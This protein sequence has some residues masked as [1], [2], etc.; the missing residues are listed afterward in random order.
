[1]PRP[2]AVEVFPNGEIGVVWDDGREDVHASR[3]LR[4]ACP[5]AQ[6]VDEMTGKRIV[7]PG[8]VSERVRAL[9]WDP[10]GHYALRIRWSDLHDSGLY[11]FEYLRKLGER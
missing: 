3:D 11:S 4:L 2:R 8:Q 6:C 7:E 1:M 10:V 9:G 5:C